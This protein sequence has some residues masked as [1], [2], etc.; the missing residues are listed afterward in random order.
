MLDHGGG[1]RACQEW[2]GR[3][4]AA[5]LLAEDRKL[6]LAEALAAVSL[7]DGDPGPAELGELLPQRRVERARLG[8]L[9]H[10]RR[11]GAFAEQVACRALDLALVVG[12]AEVHQAATFRRGRPS[13]RSATMFFSTSVVPPSIVLPRARKSS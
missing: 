3:E 12:E 5:K 1:H 7:G 9:A 10:A 11:R 8:V 13:T 4:R 2:H 6:D